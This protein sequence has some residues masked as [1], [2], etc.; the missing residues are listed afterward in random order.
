MNLICRWSSTGLA[1]GHSAVIDPGQSPVILGIE[2]PYLVS[3]RKIIRPLP[4]KL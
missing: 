2:F 3:E 1:A 4:H